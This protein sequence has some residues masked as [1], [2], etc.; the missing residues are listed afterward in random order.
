MRMKKEERIETLTKLGLSLMQAK[1][2]LSLIQIGP[3][4]A[5]SLAATIET[6]R[7]DMYRVIATLHKDGIIEKLM[8]KPAVFKAA[9]PNQIIETL[10]KRKNEA[11]NE[12]N[13]KSIEL[14]SDLLNNQTKKEIHEP[15]IDFVI[16]QGKDAIFQRLKDG[17]SK[18]E[19]SV[20][21]VTSQKRFSEAIIEFNEWYLSALKRGVT[22]FL[23][24][25]HHI[26]QKK[27]SKILQTLMKYP[28]FE[29]RFFAKTPSAIVATLDNKEAYATMSANTSLEANASMWSNNTSFVEL[30]QSYFEKK[31]NNSIKYEPPEL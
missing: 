22:V 20:N 4:T 28:N 14:I 13:K 31:W 2:Y 6:S 7:P 24:T 12:L 9:P 21:V 8:T 25:D 23:T 17:L 1:I 15:G 11:Q 10:V 3:S 5:K 27:A 29:L 19:T 30:A 16:I 18:A 26:P